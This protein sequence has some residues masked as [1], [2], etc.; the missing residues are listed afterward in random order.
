MEFLCCDEEHEETGA[1]CHLL[2][3]HTGPTHQAWSHYPGQLVVWPND[4]SPD[5]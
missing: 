4:R 3:D 2:P 5:H 1:L